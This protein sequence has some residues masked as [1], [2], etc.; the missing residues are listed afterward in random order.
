MKF[1]GAEILACL[2]ILAV[3]ATGAS[4]APAPLP[5][6]PEPPAVVSPSTIPEL[7]AALANE[8]YTTRE[9]ASNRLWQL[10]EPAIPAL[11]EAAA[12]DDPEVAYRAR[13]ILR[14]LDLFILPGT[15]P[16]VIALVERYQKASTSQKLALMDQLRNKRAYRQVLKLYAA[17]TDP[18]IRASRKQ[19]VAAMA[20]SAARAA[21]LADNPTEAR[22]LLELAPASDATL[23]TLAAFHRAQGTLEAE[24][25]LARSSNAPG[26]KAWQLALLRANGDH[27][28]AMAMAIDT[29][30]PGIGAAM[31]VLMGDPLPWLEFGAAKDNSSL[32]LYTSLAIKRWNGHR[33]GKADF[34]AITNRFN[35]RNSSSR[36]LAFGAAYLLGE[37]AI[38]EPALVKLE[39]FIA[40]FDYD[41][42][43]RVGEALEAIGLDPENPDYTG[44][45]AARFKKLI[46]DADGAGEAISELAALAAFMQNRGLDSEMADAFDQPLAKL[47]DQEIDSFTELAGAMCGRGISRGHAVGPLLRMAPAWAADDDARWENILVGIF[48]DNDDILPC[49]SF[50]AEV[51]P[52]ADRKARFAALLALSGYGPD[53]DDLRSRWLADIWKFIANANPAK[54]ATLLKYVS[55]LTGPTPDVE[56]EL[57][58]ISLRANL[59]KPGEMGAANAAAGDPDAESPLDDEEGI[60]QQDSFDSA[61][62][63]E[64]LYLATDDRWQDAA[65][66]AL[67]FLTSN[68]G[69]NQTRADLHA[70]AA[71]C[72]RRAGQNEQ[73]ATHDALVENLALG[74]ASLYLRIASGYAFGDD[75]ERALRW[76]HRA[77]CEV[78]PESIAFANVLDTFATDQ[79]NAGRWAQAAAASEV[80]AQVYSQS[81]YGGG[82]QLLLLRLRQQADLARAL[83]LLPTERDRAISLL[84]RCHELAPC[85]GSLADNFFPAIRAAGLVKEHDQWFALSWDKLQQ[86]IKRFPAGHNSRNTAAWLAARA[87]RQLDTAEA[88]LKQS[89]AAFP[90]QAAF[91]DTMAEIQFARG[92]R[93]QALEWS[94]KSINAMPTDSAIRRQYHRF[95]KDPLPQ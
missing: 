90:R 37:P 64:L 93:E 79:L 89:L 51:N 49:W 72:L 44:W 91:L 34:T 26:A 11:K 82:I 32:D 69:R 80:L 50:L 1:P 13:D 71:A 46:K 6:P 12:G 30:K 55:Y 94:R 57:K 25:K 19:S 65:E 3:A 92:H 21:L 10:G 62:A 67:G 77:A 41:S 75:Y 66:L 39:P 84:A 83:Q 43:E 58:I 76:H 38:A 20:V 68:N 87:N 47:A 28:Q 5:P 88:Q 14:K 54:L 24:L 22:S 31:A 33:L 63:M 48:G 9:A 23:V 42:E 2:A 16:A 35:S 36:Q 56:T 40:F 4:D 27:E 8:R 60:I 78:D 95:L 53:P 45:A 81:P 52:Q 86:I 59:K 18:K 73:A 61:A 29:G 85:D 74:D 15:D 17:E 70:Y 7:I